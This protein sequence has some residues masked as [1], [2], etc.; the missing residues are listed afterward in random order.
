[1]NDTRFCIG[2]FVKS[3][4]KHHINQSQ[5]LYN[6]VMEI[7]YNSLKNADQLNDCLSKEAILYL[8][9][10]NYHEI[11]KYIINIK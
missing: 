6:N 4:M 3:L 7:L 2:E 8:M 11:S 5:T 9:E 10:F 1:M